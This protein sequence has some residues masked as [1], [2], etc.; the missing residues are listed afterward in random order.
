MNENLIDARVIVT[1]EFIVRRAIDR[2]TLAK[3]Y[4]ND[5]SAFIKYLIWLETME[6]IAAEGIDII[7]VS[8]KEWSDE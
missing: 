7:D 8:A 5:L 2:E 4:D 6:G 3:E 1:C